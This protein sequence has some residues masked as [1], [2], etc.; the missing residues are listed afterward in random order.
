KRPS[1]L[2]SCWRLRIMKYPLPGSNPAHDVCSPQIGVEFARTLTVIEPLTIF[3]IFLAS[4]GKVPT[5]RRKRPPSAPLK[6]G[7]ATNGRD[8]SD[9]GNWRVATA[10]DRDPILSV[11]PR[12]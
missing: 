1:P 10:R 8:A 11:Y 12:P 6:P 3:T 2:R 9:F 5:T 4:G 7:P